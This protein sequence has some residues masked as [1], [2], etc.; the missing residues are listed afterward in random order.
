M[1]DGRL[2]VVL[3]WHMHQPWYR[4]GLDGAYRLPWVYLH[5]LKDYSDMAF[6][7]EQHPRM[8]CVVNFAPV[9]LEQLDDYAQQLSAF[10]QSGQ[11]MQ[12]RLLNLLAGIEPIPTDKEA[13]AELITECQRC[14]APRMIHPHAAFQRLLKMIGATDEVGIGSKR[15]RCSLSYLSDQYFLDLLTWYHLAWMGQSLRDLPTIKRLIEQ[16]SEFSTADRRD[17]LVVMRDCLAGIIPR[18]RALAV[19]GRVELSMTPYMHPI[20][21]LLNDFANMRCAMPDAPAPQ[22]VGYPAGEERSRWHLQRGI[23]VFEQYFGL[24]PQGVWLSEGGLSSDAVQL[25]D[26]LGIRWTASGEGVWRN[27]C[28]LSGY[29]GADEQSKRSLFMPYQQPNSQVRLFFRDD[30][31][32]DLIGF[33]YSDWHARDAV[34]DFVQHLDNI[35]AF[36]NHHAPEQVVSIILDGENAWEYY[37]NN[38]AYFLDALYAALDHS[39]QLRVT[40]FAD[41]SQRLPSR[42]MPQICAGSWVYGSFS[43]WIGSPDK[44]R[45]WDYLVEAK[46]A[47]DAVMA[48]DT[49]TPEQQELASRQLGVCEGSDWFWWFGDYNPSDS[50][51]DFERLYRRQLRKLYELLQLAAP[52]YLD[53]P[54]S[55]G[56]G[57]AENA[58]TM[59]RN[60]T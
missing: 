47:F 3:C 37:P 41:A 11:A 21:P 12:D 14:H 46:L 60:V 5:G 54:I 19:S 17:L 24:K 32:S 35:A 9:L 48:A 4:D 31:L 45:G 40:T 53:R 49:L 2:N 44:N 58:G 6:H 33:K 16:G 50:V 20:V 8:R 7:L 22:A 23:A 13:R 52:D 27:S 38:G 25:L 56:G 28:R 26:E 55:E 15:F 51:R 57:N 43:T 36:L 1:A 34:A 42:V 59:R 18:Y 10:L 30:G 39:D 29:N